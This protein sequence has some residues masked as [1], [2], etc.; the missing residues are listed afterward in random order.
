MIGTG[1]YGIVRICKNRKTKQKFAVKTII[2]NDVKN[3][4][5]LRR[6]VGVLALLDHPNIVRLHDL[7]ENA[8]HLHIVTELCTGGELY[9][10]VVQK[11]QSPE[12]HFSES[13]AAQI[14][15]SVLDAV[16]YCHDIHHIVHRDLKAENFLLM[17]REDGEDL[18]VKIIDFGFSRP[19][20]SGV[21]TSRV[22]TCS[23]LDRERVQAY[24]NMGYALPAYSA[25]QYV[26]PRSLFLAPSIGTT[27]YVAPEVLKGAYTSKCDIW[28]IGVLT[29]VVLC[30]H[31]PFMGK[32][33]LET[34]ELVETGKVEF[35]PPDWIDQSSQ[36]KDFIRHLL[37]LDTEQRPTA[38]QAME[39]PWLLARF[40]PHEK[41]QKKGAK[42]SG[43]QKLLMKVSLF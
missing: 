13:E 20:V 32:T 39:H 3:I 18:H 28:S 25:D 40:V 35:Q 30:G 17:H 12:K 29:F 34:L 19:Y 2:K 31:A 1:S 7:Y 27:Y 16:A 36:A 10:H 14:I 6:E 38:R 37:Q 26:F 23:E 21:M 42:K 9:D 24:S 5:A 43:F 15:Y 11:F 33:E 8:Y 22:G 41:T 4:E